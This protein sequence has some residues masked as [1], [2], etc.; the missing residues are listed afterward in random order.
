M[1]GV[2]V[3]LRTKPAS[4]AHRIPEDKEWIG[5]RRWA[6]FVDLL[7][8]KTALIVEPRQVRKDATVGK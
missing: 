8:G 4:R 2:A 5:L 7:S 1:G 3:H 6:P